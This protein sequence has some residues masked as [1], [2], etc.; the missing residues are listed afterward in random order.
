M[1]KRDN[2]SKDG[3]NGGDQRQ[4]QEGS[5]L[6]PDETGRVATHLFLASGAEVLRILQALA[7]RS[8]GLAYSLKDED[9]SLETLYARAVQVSRHSAQSLDELL[10]KTQVLFAL[11]DAGLRDTYPAL[12]KSIV[13]DAHLLRGRGT[14]DFQETHAAAAAQAADQDIVRLEDVSVSLEQMVEAG[15]KA[16]APSSQLTLF[17]PPIGAYA[18]A[19]AMIA[20]VERILKLE[21]G[22]ADWTGMRVAV[23]AAGDGVGVAA[24]IM[25]A[26]AGAH[27]QLVAHPGLDLHESLAMA[28]HR[29]NVDLELVSAEADDQKKKIIA[30]AEV[31]LAAAAPGTR[32]IDVK[33]MAWAEILTVVAD[34]NIVPPSGVEGME[35]YM[36]GTQ[37]PGCI[38][39]GVG[40][41]TIAN[42]RRKM[43]SHLLVQI[44][45]SAK[46][47][48]LS[49]PEVLTF[50]RRLAA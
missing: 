20:C 38:A 1:Q 26:L 11:L 41:L 21:Y 30:S 3:S 39:L 24:S 40:P 6:K 28:K 33:H 27:V 29:F 34:T 48:S 16:K 14:E 32:I 10:L 44:L 45:L 18:T 23:F 50:A 36:D 12:A 47:L 2:S 15:T 7:T 9:I 35:P 37:L 4:E 43:E 5:G 49:L 31:V 13:D 19:A 42:M 22:H 17:A 46:P 8:A 25:A